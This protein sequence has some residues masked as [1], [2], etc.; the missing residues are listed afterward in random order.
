M[1]SA[2]RQTQDKLARD[3]DSSTGDDKIKISNLDQ[4]IA[5]DEVWDI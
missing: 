1:K 2:L 5:N 4:G 3:D